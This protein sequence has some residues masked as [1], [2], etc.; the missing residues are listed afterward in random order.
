MAST[1]ILK[2][3]TSKHTDVV[4]NPTKTAFLFFCLRFE[5]ETKAL[6]GEVKT[7][8]EQ[9]ASLKTRLAGLQVRRKSERDLAARREEVIAAVKSCH[10]V[11]FVT[12]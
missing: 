5:R 11:A 12:D 4:I 3:R 1:I 7:L 6:K 9:V 8:K 10:A 2:W